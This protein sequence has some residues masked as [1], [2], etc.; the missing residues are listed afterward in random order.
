MSDIFEKI[1]DRLSLVEVIEEYIPVI[2][3]GGRTVCLCP[4]HQEKSPS[5]S[6]S[7]DKGV[8]YC[9]GCGA[10]GN[11]FTF[12]CNMDNLSKKEALEKLA[13]KAGVDLEQGGG[14]KEAVDPRI[15]NG[16][17]LLESI[18]S[19]Y[20][21]SLEMHMGQATSSAE[22]VSQ[23]VSQY[24]SA[25]KMTSKT[26]AD[27]RI[28]YAP[29]AGFLTSFLQKNNIPLSLGADVGLLS[30]IEVYNPDSQE[31]ETSYKDRF[32]DRLMI[33]ICDEKGRVVGFTGRSFPGDK[34]K[35]RPKYLNS[36]ESEFFNKSNILYGLNLAK[37]SIYKSGK[38]ILVEGNMDV[39][40]AHQNGLT[41]CIATQGTAVTATHIRNIKRL[42]TPVYLA[43]D[44]DNAGVIAEK[45]A[46]KM[47]LKEDVECF[48][49]VFDR[50]YKDLDEFLQ[51][52]DKSS[53]RTV[54]YLNYLILATPAL[55][56]KDMYQQRKAI[57]EVMDYASEANAIFQDQ[58][59][60][61]LFDK[62]G[63]SKEAIKTIAKE[64]VSVED[65]TEN[66]Q[67]I[68]LKNLSPDKLSGLKKSFITIL[69]YSIKDPILA[70]IYGFLR[71][72]DSEV[73]SSLTLDD[74]ILESEGLIGLFKQQS[75]GKQEDFKISTQMFISN[76]IPSLLSSIDISSID[77]Q[78]MDTI[79]ELETYRRG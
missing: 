79:K 27:F 45:R 46:F 37:N 21:K 51:E 9:F 52:N 13:L 2:N 74:Y 8:Y 68:R 65:K 28:G 76:L 73:F 14:K 53:I 58:V 35:D 33:P 67:N 39:V 75:S 23:Y 17:K 50:K 11:M 7:N 63:I 38:M 10:S 54:P 64:R 40:V 18:A 22:H 61:A 16:Y 42:K 31:V 56:S 57:V 26:L 12:V 25:R 3:R 66:T 60:A 69:G 6:I 72:I 5:F 71:V 55:G 48:K 1:Q 15:E 30:V 32:K 36:P 43:F 62:T 4:F 41:Q 24:V 29:E 59:I 77:T 19:L 34:F 20:Q 70:S 49:V 44:N 78:T 47:L